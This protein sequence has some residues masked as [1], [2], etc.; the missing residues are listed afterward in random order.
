MFSL[1][2]FLILIQ[3]PVFRSF[4]SSTLILSHIILLAMTTNRRILFLVLM[5]Y[6]RT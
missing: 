5:R 6:C 1:C 4:T 3:V 2:F